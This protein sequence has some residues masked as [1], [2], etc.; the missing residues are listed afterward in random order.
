MDFT[1]AQVTS[2]LDGKGEPAEVMSGLL[3]KWLQHIRDALHSQISA[4]A[5]K[6]A[7]ENFVTL[8]SNLD[9][10]GKARFLVSP[11]V[12][13]FLEEPDAAAYEGERRGQNSVFHAMLGALRREGM[14]TA[15]RNGDAPREASSEQ[16][17]RSPLGDLSAH[18]D[19]G[20]N[21]WNLRAAERIGGVICIDFDSDL[22]ERYEPES[23]TFS[24]P[25]LPMSPDE[26]S[27]TVSKLERAL[28][29]IDAAMPVYG[30][31]IRNFTRRIIVRKT[32][33]EEPSDL[34]GTVPLALASEFR[35]VHTG[36]I[37][38]LN[39]HRDEMD[40]VL[41]MESLVHETVHSMLSCYE[42]LYGKFMS[43]RVVVRPMSPWSGNLIPN[44]SLAHAVFVY[45]AIYRLFSE[46]GTIAAMLSAAE[47]RQ[48]AKRICDVSIGFLVDRP[49]SCLFFLDDGPSDG[50]FDA[51]DELQREIQSSVPGSEPIPAL[52]R[53][54]A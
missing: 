42:D 11:H 37:R 10:V 14:I 33:G 12:S 5:D 4:V 18:Y 26:K 36:C 16:I 35:P 19:P 38:L 48:V 39:V 32:S 54:A 27:A 2:V 41:C 9:S 13:E 29:L 50:F 6:E 3:T 31:M 44:H 17:V 34:V 45:Y 46:A 51:I 24:Q 47:K 43:T 1:M 40:V 20:Q 8:Y 25:R 52:S 21:A 22:S 30:L 53:N 7:A 15:I 23:G 28:E 49:L